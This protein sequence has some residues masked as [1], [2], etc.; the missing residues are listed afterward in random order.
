MKSPRTPALLAVLGLASLA[1]GSIGDVVGNALGA[2]RDM[3]AVAS[4]W[5]DV[6]PMEGMTPS[7]QVDMPAWLKALARPMMDGMMRGLNDGNDAGHWDWTAYSLSGET[8]SDVQGFYTPE[9]MAASG[10]QQAE[11][12]CLPLGEQAGLCSFTREGPG[13]ATGLIIIAAADEQKAETSV[14]FL[15]AE[16]AGASPATAQPAATSA[17]LS[18]LPV[19]PIAI[20]SDLTTIDLCQA[21][22]AADVEAVL[23]RTLAKPPERFDYYATPGTSGCFYEGEKDPSGEAHYGY[24]ALTPVEAFNTQPLYLNVPVSGLGEEAY[25]NNGADTRQLW[26]R[27]DDA[28]ALVVAFGDVANEDH[29]RSIAE[30][31]LAALQ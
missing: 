19:A 27:I 2:E 5:S 7:Q 26:V 31:V 14:F 15:R 30:L 28:A 21:I 6:P 25:F 1:C 11:A 20:G 13:R 16:G 10:W 9:R 12:T 3:S 8:P 24:V 22:P 29:E 17:P 18:L 4:L 23:G